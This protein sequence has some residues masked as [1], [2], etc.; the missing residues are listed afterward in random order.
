VI[1]I[2]AL[3]L[4][5]FL[6]LATAILVK[7]FS[8][9][10]TE[11]GRETP[12]LFGPKGDRFDLTIN[13]LFFSGDH[14]SQLS[15]ADFQLLSEEDRGTMVPLSLGFTARKF[16]VIGT[17]SDYF[18]AR[19][20][21]PK[22]GTIPLKLGEAVLGS[23]CAEK[24]NTQI[25]E[26]ILT[27]QVNLY[28]L[29]ASY[30]LKLKIV[31]ILNQTN[32]ADDNAIFTSMGTAWVISGLGHGHEPINES[33]KTDK[34]L[35]KTDK[36]ITANASLEQ[37]I[38]INEKNIN[39]FHFH[40]DP[41]QLPVTSILAFPKSKKDGTILKAKYLQHAQIQPLG[42]DTVIKELLDIVIRLKRLFDASYTITVLAA[43][44]FLTAVIML[45]L[46]TRKRESKALFLMGC[47][48]GTICMIFSAEIIILC[49]F[50]ILFALLGAS[51]LTL[52]G[53]DILQ[54]LR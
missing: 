37:F 46:Q 16:P 42:P 29:S 6:P 49:L 9:S 15:M 40:S 22:T 38:E 43:F 19:K 36:Q 39:E 51:A 52:M 27:D 35:S 50:S 24:L 5:F 20:I 8:T 21:T 17:S 13:S 2:A 45:S 48:R 4:T 34:L 10:I 30:P 12:L 23:D 1:Q 14:S 28:D 11:R 31:G 7:S 33:T 44:L 25:N 53:S 3:T 26:H 47:S 54:L 32:S 18:T 41:A